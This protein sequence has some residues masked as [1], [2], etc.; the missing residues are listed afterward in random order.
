MPRPLLWFPLLIL[1]TILGLCGCA[2]TGVNKLFSRT[3][4]AD[5]TAMEPDEGVGRVPYPAEEAD[6]SSPD[7]FSAPSIART[8]EDDLR[9]G[10]QQEN[11]GN[12][13]EAKLV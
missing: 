2:S 10:Q 8:L 6:N 12:F 11:Y 5:S 1:P 3:D 4:N 7:L 13:A 9:T